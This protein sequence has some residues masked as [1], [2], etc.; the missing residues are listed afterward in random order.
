MN[1]V[2]TGL[3]SIPE[4]AIA[5]SIYLLGSAIIL[6][7]WYEIAKR[8]VKHIKY[9]SLVN[10]IMDKEVVKELIQRELK[11]ENLITELGNIL[12]GEKRSAVLENYTILREKL[13]GS[14]A[15]EKA[16]EIILK[17]G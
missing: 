2:M 9:I 16:A 7:C 11:T 13:G 15:S 14:G 8:L 5:V 6:W 17:K 10:L 12:E 1:S 3:D 4:T